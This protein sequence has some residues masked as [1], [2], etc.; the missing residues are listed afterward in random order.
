VRILWVS[1]IIPFPPKSGV[2]QRSYHLLRGVSR[3][4]SV[5]LVSFIQ[6]PWLRVFYPSREEGIQDCREHLLEICR[7]VAFLPIERLSRSYGKART[8]LEALIY[9]DSYTMRWLQSAS[10][11][12][13][14]LEQSANNHYDLVHF[15]TISLAPFRGAF[16]ETPATLGHHN[17]ESQLLRRR[18]ENE[19]H[20][21]KRWYFGREGERVR[22]SEARTAK[23]FAAH[24]TC[25]ALDSDRLR[26]IAP[27]ANAV[28]I[29]NGVDTKYFSPR[30]H[31]ASAL[32][33]I[34]FVG[35][36]NWYPNVEAVKFLL[37]EIWPRVLERRRDIELNIVGSA[38]PREIFELAKILAGVHVHGFVD[39]VRPLMNEAV[40]YV[41][42]IRDGGGTKLKLL[43]AFAMAKCVIAHPIACEGINVTS[44]ENVVIAVSPENFVEG[45]VG[46][47]NDPARRGRIGTA[48]RQLVV[49]EYSFETIGNKLCDVLEGVS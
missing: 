20:K 11:T 45:I 26:E 29:P 33:S 10:A 22:S 18:A 44:G 16:G 19:P 15:D 14:F 49:D 36:L 47:L 25:S 23:H 8:A 41:C 1:H 46:L 6:E 42:P 38:P 4:H 31:S 2:H 13:T 21:I 40:L 24:L 7:S 48:A 5:D 28:T 43:D 30:G 32:Q 27:D 35:S 12:R 9:G 3:R 39:D 34:I 37:K 17:I